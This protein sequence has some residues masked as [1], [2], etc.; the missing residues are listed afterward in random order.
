MNDKERLAA[1]VEY[2]QQEV[3]RIDDAMRHFPNE[4]GC[5]LLVPVGLMLGIMIMI[6]ERLHLAWLKYKLSTLKEG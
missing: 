2:Q 3:E 6:F 1:E 4:G 5:L